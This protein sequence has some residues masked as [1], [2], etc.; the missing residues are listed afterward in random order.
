MQEVTWEMVEAALD[1]QMPEWRELPGWAAPMVA[2][3]RMKR[4]LEAAL[5]VASEPIS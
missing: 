4:A 1:V 5:A 2:G 3:E